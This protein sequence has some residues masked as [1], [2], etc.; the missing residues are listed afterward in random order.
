[1]GVHTLQQLPSS[2]LVTFDNSQVAL[3]GV[4]GTHME[5]HHCIVDEQISLGSLCA[6]FSVKG[7]HKQQTSLNDKSDQQIWGF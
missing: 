4:F 2:L 5:R 6:T 1:M 3:G 7:P